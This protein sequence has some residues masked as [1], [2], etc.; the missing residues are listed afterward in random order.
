LVGI[1]SN[2]LYAYVPM[3]ITFPQKDWWGWVYKSITEVI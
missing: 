3:C 1:F 2:T